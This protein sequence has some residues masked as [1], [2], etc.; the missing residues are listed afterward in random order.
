MNSVLPSPAERFAGKLKMVC[1]SCIIRRRP[2]GIT[3]SYEDRSGLLLSAEEE[4]GILTLF[5]KIIVSPPR[6][7]SR[8]ATDSSKDFLVLYPLGKASRNQQLFKRLTI[9]CI[10]L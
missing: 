7:G 4:F 8:E 5:L 3:T 6:K 10:C 2:H 1:E 9:D